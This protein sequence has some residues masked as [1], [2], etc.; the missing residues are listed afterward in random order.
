MVSGVLQA[1]GGCGWHCH[2][3][4]GTRPVAAAGGTVVSTM[5][6]QPIVGLSRRRGVLRCEVWWPSVLFWL[7]LH[8]EIS[9]KIR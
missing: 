4:W 9:K 6:P 8:L 1:G 5:S 2:L 3:G 7:F